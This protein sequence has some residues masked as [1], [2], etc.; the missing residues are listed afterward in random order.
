MLTSKPVLKARFLVATPLTPTPAET[1]AMSS[2][3]YR[4]ALVKSAKLSLLLTDALIVFL[5]SYSN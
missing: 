1:V 5:A 4:G 2:S 3:P